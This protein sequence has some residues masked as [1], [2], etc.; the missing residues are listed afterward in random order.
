MVSTM[1]QP[2]REEVYTEYG[3]AFPISHAFIIILCGFT[4]YL[5]CPHGI[6]YIIASLSLSCY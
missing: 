4:E 5:I 2:H 1:S 6:L 3:F